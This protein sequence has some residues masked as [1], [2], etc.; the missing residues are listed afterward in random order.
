MNAIKFEG[1]TIHSQSNLVNKILIP[2][3]ILLLH[4]DFG[5]LAHG[6]RPKGL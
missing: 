1:A 2:A 5:R 6:R 4:T 3:G